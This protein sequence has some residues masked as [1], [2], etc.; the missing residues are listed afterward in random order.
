[1][2]K[3]STDA[4]AKLW[5]ILR[6]RRLAGF[7]FRRQHR[8]AGYTL[9]FY[10]AQRRLA[11]ELDGGQHADPAAV[12]YDA[13]RTKRMSEIGVRVLRFWDHDVLKDPQVVAEEI[14]RHLDAEEPSPRPSPGVPGEGVTVY[15]PAESDK[16]Q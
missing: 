7:K 14:Y 5:S 2:R 6:G 12:H 13:Q 16:K 15:R 11:I 10:C 9:D 1:M 3:S 4:E 8:V